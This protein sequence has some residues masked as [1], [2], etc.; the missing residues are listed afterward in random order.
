MAWTTPLKCS[1]SVGQNAMLRYVSGQALAEDA[2]IFG[3]Q[4]AS[5]EARYPIFR[6][7][8]EEREKIFGA[9]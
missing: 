5:V 1:V 6:S 7:D 4:K 9:R 3:A 2:W 8:R